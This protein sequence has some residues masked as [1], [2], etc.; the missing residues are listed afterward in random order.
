M[1]LWQEMSSHNIA[2]ILSSGRVRAAS[3]LTAVHTVAAAAAF[4]A[5]AVHLRRLRRL[6]YRVGEW[7][8]AFAQFLKV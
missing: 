7:D 6:D 4:V 1:S 8:K 3:V 2:I 5:A